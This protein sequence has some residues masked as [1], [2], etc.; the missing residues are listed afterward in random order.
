MRQTALLSALITLLFAWALAAQTIAIKPRFQSVGHFHNGLAPAQENDRWGFIDMRGE[1]VVTPRYDGVLR[2]GSGRFGIRE[3]G[4]WG[5]ID[6]GGEVIIPPTYDDARPFVGG[7]AAVK[8]GGLWGFVS[9]TGAIETVIEFADIG[10]REG[11]LFPARRAGDPWRT[12]RATTGLRAAAYMASDWDDGSVHKAYLQQP[13]QEVRPS[14]VYGFSEGAT[15]AVFDQGEALLNTRGRAIS[16][17]NPFFKSIRRRSEGVAAATRDGRIWGYIQKNGDFWRH[18]G[19]T[20]A[21][22][23][24][25]GVAPVKRDGKWGYLNKKGNLALQPRYDRAYSFHE[26]FAT[27]R[28]GQKRGFLKLENG[29][30]TEFVSPRY[31]DV[32]RFQ[33]G[34]APIKMG[35]LWG[36]LSNGAAKPEVRTRDVVDLIP[37]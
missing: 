3:N 12:M 7:V 6:V 23:F 13:L 5:F 8:L 29:R 11:R 24:S 26:G 27:M 34:L 14:K 17:D 35:G 36:F 2:G 16:G 4:R 21:R 1:W 10:R 25:E 37:E 20:G 31:E 28:V 32:F 19:Y 22:E 30:I 18:G 9:A 33:E 15:V